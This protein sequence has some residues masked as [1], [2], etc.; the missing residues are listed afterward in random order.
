M[1][2]LGSERSQE[3]RMSTETGSMGAGSVKRP[4]GLKPAKLQGRVAPVLEGSHCVCV[5]KPDMELQDST[6]ALMFS[7]VLQATS[8]YLYP[9]LFN[10]GCDI[11]ILTAP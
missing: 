5:Q 1:E 2:I 9:S 3:D 10:E 8:P 4:R 7:A 6:F 11:V